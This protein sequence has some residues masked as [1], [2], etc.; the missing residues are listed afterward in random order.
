MEGKNQAIEVSGRVG[1]KNQSR[2]ESRR[3]G[4]KNEVKKNIRKGN[5]NSGVEGVRY[6]LH[7]NQHC[8]RQEQSHRSKWES[9]GWKNR[10]RRGS[11]RVKQKNYRDSRIH[12][13]KG[14]QKHHKEYSSEE[15]KNGA[16]ISSKHKEDSGVKGKNT[17]RN[18]KSHR[19]KKEL[20]T[21]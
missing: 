15:G 19:K 1:G 13:D 5:E 20:W 9:I 12:N 11:R 21:T 3:L 16:K 6:K 8:G 17:A 10:A 4:R 18:N 2:R 7:G 14:S